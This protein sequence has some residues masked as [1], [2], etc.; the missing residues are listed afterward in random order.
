MQG[1]HNAG[2]V[3]TRGWPGTTQREDA[4]G[5]DFNTM[6]DTTIIS[7]ARVVSGGVFSIF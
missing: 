5:G 1:Q 4:N 7:I 2:Q 3:R 6:L